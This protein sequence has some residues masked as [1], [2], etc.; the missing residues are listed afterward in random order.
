MSHFVDTTKKLDDKDVIFNNTSLGIIDASKIRLRLSNFQYKPRQSPWCE[1]GVQIC[2]DVKD[3]SL[4]ASV[5]DY[6][7]DHEYLIPKRWKKYQVVF[8]GTIYRFNEES[9]SSEG[10]EFVRCLYFN[11]I[12]KKWGSAPLVVDD[13]FGPNSPIAYPASPR[14]SWKDIAHKI[15]D[16]L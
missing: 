5:L 14:Q 10:Q 1:Y 7:L 3:E 12:L 8:W 2:K 15:I 16:K 4:N 13:Y 9:G 11:K 6:L